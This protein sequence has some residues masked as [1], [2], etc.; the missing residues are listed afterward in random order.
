[1][2]LTIFT[3][4]FTSKFLHKSQSVAM[5]LCNKQRHCPL[6][7]VHRTIYL[8][9]KLDCHENFLKLSCQF[10]IPC[11]SDSFLSIL[12]SLEGQALCLLRYFCA[13]FRSLLDRSGIKSSSGLASHQLVS[14]GPP[15]LPVDLLL[16]PHRK[17][18][19]LGAEVP[20]MIGGKSGTKNATPTK[21]RCISHGTHGD[22]LEAPGLSP[23]P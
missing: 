3:S 6:S 16:R 14:A 12:R 20:V 21:C 4:I 17:L 2:Y 10:S 22:T 9:L 1:M 7:K 19:V 5:D 15:P 13:T 8:L 18:K 23:R 11:W